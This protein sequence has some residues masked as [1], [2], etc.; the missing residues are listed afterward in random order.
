MFILAQIN[1]GKL[2]DKEKILSINGVSRSFGKTK[3]LKGLSIA[4][5]KGQIVGLLGRNGAGKSTLLR[6]VGGMLKPSG[7]NVRIADQKVWD[8]AKAL[9]QLCIIGDTPDFGKLNK[10]KDLF[11]VS[12]GLFPGWDGQL[13]HS[14]LKRFELPENRKIKTFSRGM[15]TSLMLIVGLASRAPFTIIDEPSLGLDA[16]MRERFYDLLLEQKK[17]DTDRTF[18]ISTHLI[19]EVAR[20]L[21]YAVMIDDGN[22]LCEGTVE[23]LQEGTLSVSGDAADVQELTKDCKILKEEDL[24]GML[25]RHVQ[26]DAETMKVIQADKRVRSGPIGLQRLFVFL[27]EEK[28]AQRNG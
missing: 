10:I 14:L 3:A 5:P 18:L 11:F 2:T 22:L 28:E 16:V 15:Q 9:G 6:I 4:I 13:A 20:L 26:L 23:Q 24:A 7:G 12:A 25:V 21:D 17:R 1:P 19:D 8:H 27:T